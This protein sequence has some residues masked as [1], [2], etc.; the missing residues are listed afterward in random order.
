MIIEPQYQEALNV[1]PDG[2]AYVKNDLG[3]WD[4]LIIYKLYYES[5]VF[6]NGG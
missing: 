5:A 3:Y 2:V 4:Y 1:M 6:G